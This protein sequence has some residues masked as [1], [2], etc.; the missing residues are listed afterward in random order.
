MKLRNL[1]WLGIESDDESYL[2][3]PMNELVKAV[4]R[5]TS[6]LNKFA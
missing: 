2:Y 5:I 6:A 1:P 3:L 4:I